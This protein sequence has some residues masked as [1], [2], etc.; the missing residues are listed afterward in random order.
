MGNMTC[1]KKAVEFI[2][3]ALYSVCR[4]RT[5]TFFLMA[6]AIECYYDGVFTK[7]DCPRRIFA[8]LSIILHV[9]EY[10]IIKTDLLPACCFIK[11]NL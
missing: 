4:R 9:S 8:Y 3:P 7:R 10:Q 2:P 11:C 5:H 6:R 1:V